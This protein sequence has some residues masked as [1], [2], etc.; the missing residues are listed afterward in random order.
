MRKPYSKDYDSLLEFLDWTDQLDNTFDNAVVCY[1]WDKPTD[2]E[3]MRL[4]WLYDP[5]TYND[6]PYVSGR[7]N[8]RH[9][10][11]VTIETK[12]V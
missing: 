3:V 11:P 12:E 10:V 8:W 9:A 1:V 2:K 5:F 7:C 4:V 6:Y